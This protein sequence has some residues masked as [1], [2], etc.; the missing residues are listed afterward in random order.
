MTQQSPGQIVFTLNPVKEVD[1]RVFIFRFVPV[2]TIAPDLYD[3]VQLIVKG[4]PV[5]EVVPPALSTLRGV[6]ASLTCN[7]E[8][9][10]L[11]NIT[12]IRRTSSGESEISSNGVDVQINSGNGSSQLI[13]QNTSTADSG[14]YI[15]H[16]SNYVSDTARAFIGVVYPTSY[17]DPDLCPI[18]FDATIDES[19]LMCC[20]VHGFPPPQVSWELPNGTR[21][22]KGSTMLHVTVKTENDFGRYRCIARSLEKNAL[23]ADITIRKRISE[24][25]EIDKK[26][27]LKDG[28]KLAWEKVP[29]ASYYLLIL[30]E[31]D[32]LKENSLLGWNT[33]TSVEIPYSS[34]TFKSN[35]KERPREVDT[36]VEVWAFRNSRI[37]GNGTRYTNVVIR[38]GAT[39]STVSLMTLL[40]SFVIY[41]Q[42]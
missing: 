35:I 12:W 16:A 42:Q 2:N 13:I 31:T 38:A 17:E 36:K 3:M 23:T 20:P 40:L 26:I 33:S 18:R 27:I 6:K 1:N 7:A 14:Y 24:T 22:E 32:F 5:V 25:Y 15:C 9:F 11:P 4:P 28:D 8:G 30:S 37:I 34:L 21:L 41:N 19:V 10:P 39:T 29:G